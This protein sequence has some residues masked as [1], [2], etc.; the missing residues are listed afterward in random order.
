M[1]KQSQND[2][3]LGYMRAHKR[4][5]TPKVALNKYGCFRL[6]ARIADLRRMGYEIETHRECKK[7]NGQ[8]LQYARYTLE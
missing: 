2:K 1:R 5:I 8:V 6:A 4:G 3:I 7:N